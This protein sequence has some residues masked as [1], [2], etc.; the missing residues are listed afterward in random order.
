MRHLAQ[1][2]AEYYFTWENQLHVWLL[3]GGMVFATVVVPAI[4]PVKHW[5]R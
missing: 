4:E 3:I 2:F 5:A 1:R